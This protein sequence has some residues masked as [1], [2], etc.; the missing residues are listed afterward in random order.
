MTSYSFF[1]WALRDLGNPALHLV[2]HWRPH[3]KM[4]FWNIGAEGQVLA[5]GLATV[6]IMVNVTE[7]FNNC[8]ASG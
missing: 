6:L 5:G 1:K 2:L 3:L 8:I 7:S 4:K